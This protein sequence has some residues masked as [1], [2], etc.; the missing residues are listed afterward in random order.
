MPDPFREKGSRKILQVEICLIFNGAW[1]G[2]EWA[3]KK[4]N[5]EEFEFFQV[6][7][8]CDR[9][10]NIPKSSFMGYP[11]TQFHPPGILRLP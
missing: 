11:N 8:F 1:N 3:A 5:L 10:C 7:G 2:S 9:M 4:D 6:F